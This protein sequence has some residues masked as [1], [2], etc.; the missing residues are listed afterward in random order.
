M[1]FLD[2]FGSQ[3]KLLHTITFSTTH[4]ITNLACRTGH[5]F[6]LCLIDSFSDCLI[7]TVEFVVILNALVVVEL[8]RFDM[9]MGIIIIELDGIYHLSPLI[10]HPFAFEDSPQFVTFPHCFYSLHSFHFSHVDGH[11]EVLRC[12]HLDRAGYVDRSLFLVSSI[13]RI[14]DSFRNYLL[15]VVQAQADVL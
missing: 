8:S 3:P 14:D 9:N 7:P 12:S 11:G 6:S 4:I 13:F 1:C 5:H 2:S 10:L 15:V